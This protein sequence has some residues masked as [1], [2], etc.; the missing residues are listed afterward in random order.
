MGFRRYRFFGRALQGVIDSMP[1]D[2]IAPGASL[3]PHMHD[4]GVT[5]S[6]FGSFSPPLLQPARLGT[7][8]V[9][10][11]DETDTSKDDLYIRPEFCRFSTDHLTLEANLEVI[12]ITTRDQG[13]EQ[14]VAGLAGRLLEALPSSPVREFSIARYAHFALDANQR[15]VDVVTSAFDTVTPANESDACRPPAKAKNLIARSWQGLVLPTMWGQVLHRPRLDEV[16]VRGDRT[17]DR[18]G[19]VLVTIEPSLIVPGGAF[20]A[21]IDVIQPTVALSSDQAPRGTEISALQVAT[22][23]R[24]A[25]QPT[26]DAAFTTFETIRKSLTSD[27]GE[28]VGHG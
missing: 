15:P 27:S 26:R 7:L 10:N 4:Y 5:V 24:V 20:I 22:E 13:S 16:T 21:R 11:L 18:D 2:A 25:W 28:V 9:L 6:F 17:D 12:E 3:L 8:G 1:S 19:S 14:R 23:L